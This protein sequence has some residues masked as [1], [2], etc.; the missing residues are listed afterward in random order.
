[1]ILRIRYENEVRSIELD[2]EATEGLWVSLDL[3]TEEDITQPERE[4]RIQDAFDEK[5]N[6]PEYN[7]WH[8]ETR[9]IDPTP[10]RKRM[11][12][13]CGYIQADPDDTAFDIM[14]YLLTTDDIETHDNNFEYQEICAWIRATLVKKPKWADAFI[15][16]RLDGM[17]VND[18]AASIGVKDASVVSKW[19]TR[20]TKKLKE[21]WKNRQI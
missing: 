11:D 21:N 19:L 8:K 7:N 13:R 14:D 18:Y 17:S 5:F 2:A 12:G 15:A 3:E 6:R 16:V 1:M 4:K 20:A 10:K 9:H